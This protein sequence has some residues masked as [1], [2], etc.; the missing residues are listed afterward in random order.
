LNYLYLVLAW[1][2]FGLLHSVL[3]AGA[4]KRWAMQRMGGYFKYY[5][6]AYSIFATINLLVVLRCHFLCEGSILWNPPL[7]EDIIALLA[8]IAGL[9][10][11]AICIA[12]YFPN[13]SGV[14]AVLG[15][16]NPPIL[17]QGGMHKYVRHPL[18]SGTLLFVWAIFLGYPY[19]NNLI[20]CVCI[21]VYTVI[22]TY[23][24]EK[25]LL[26]EFGESYRRF[27]AEVPM[28]IPGKIFK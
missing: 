19:L 20:S 21:T 22:G 16:I 7:I 14:D 23:F 6:L 4:V 9:V 24:E 26:G 3:A 13:L 15:T 8:A 12:K 28:F 25:K 1:L 17:E 11:M 5:R 18:Y 27:Q 10:V 2:V